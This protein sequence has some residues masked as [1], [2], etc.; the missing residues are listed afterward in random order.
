MAKEKNFNEFGFDLPVLVN[1]E[2]NEYLKKLKLA[3][4]IK[5]KTIVNPDINTD[6]SNITSEDLLVKFNN[7]SIEKI[8]LDKIIPRNFRSASVRLNVKL[9]NIEKPL[10]L[11]KMLGT[12]NYGLLYSEEE[13]QKITFKHI[14]LK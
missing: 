8:E 6:L 9:K 4:S 11:V 13:L 2:N 7:E 10:K 14:I 12:Q 5:V 1:I 3:E